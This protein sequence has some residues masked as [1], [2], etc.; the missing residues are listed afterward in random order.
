[1]AIDSDDARTDMI[2][3]GAAAAFGGTLRNLATQVPGYPRAGLAAVVVELAWLIAVTALVPLLLARYRGDN[4]TPFG[5]H[6]PIQG[7]PAGF[8]LALPVVA[9]AAVVGITERPRLPATSL[10]VAPSGG[11]TAG[12]PGWWW[13]RL[14]P[15]AS[16]NP[17]P[18]TVV[19]VIMQ[20]V[21]LVAGTSVLIAFVA[22]RGSHLS[23]S[24]H[25]S[26]VRLVRTVGMGAL[27]AATLGG[28]V[29][30]AMGRSLVVVVAHLITVTIMLAIVDRQVRVAPPMR[31]TEVLAPVIV[32]TALHVLAAGGLFRANFLATIHA[33]GLAGAVTVAAIVITRAGRQRWAIVP[34]MLAVYWW[35]LCLSPLALGV[36]GRC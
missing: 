28:L 15:L 2:L 9:L 33:A 30:I 11:W 36:T 31:R 29:R 10:L 19:A 26:P 1:M 22:E 13:G 35:P 24:P 34:V 12:Q 25:W 3:A 18:V 32:V 8:V 14:A 17:D 6:R 7:L 20:L 5:F 16:S 21:V 4:L 27:A 23:R